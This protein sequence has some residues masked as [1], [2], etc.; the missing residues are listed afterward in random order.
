MKPAEKSPVIWPV[1][2][3]TTPKVRESIC[4]SCERVHQEPPGSS[5]MCLKCGAWMVTESVP[6]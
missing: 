6:E 3:A 2:V 1:P 4:P 5:V